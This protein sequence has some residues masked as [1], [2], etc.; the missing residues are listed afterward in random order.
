MMVLRTADRQLLHGLWDGLSYKEVAGRLGVSHQS[1][2]DQMRR[3][4]NRIGARSTIDLFR[5]CVREGV[6]TP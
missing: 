6:L 5:R 3:I 1:V 4:R 2:K